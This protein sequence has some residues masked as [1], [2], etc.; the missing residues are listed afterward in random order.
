MPSWTFPTSLTLAA[1]ALAIAA[2]AFTTPFT[3]GNAEAAPTDHGSAGSTRAAR[4]TVETETRVIGYSVQ[5]RP[6]K[7]VRYG[8]ANATSVGVFIGEIHGTERAGIPVVKQLRQLGPPA[9]S[10]MWIVKTVNPDGHAAHSRKNARGVDLN[11]NSPHLWKSTSRAPDYYP[12]RSAVSEPETRA[13]LDFLGAIDPDV[14]LIY[15]QAGNGV[16]TYQA[17]SPSLVKRLARRMRLAPKSFNCDGEC[18]GTLTGWF[19][20]RP[21]RKGPAITIELP[22]HTTA[23]QVRRWARAARWSI[24]AAGS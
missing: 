10:A 16:D 4:A 20:H 14:V 22:A 17:K 1:G 7:A 24:S 5:G 23:A 19:N 18:T 11:R 13:Y 8:P 2:F 21:S 6:I 12:G 9:G 3:A 15:H